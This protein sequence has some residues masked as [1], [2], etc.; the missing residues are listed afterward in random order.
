MFTVGSPSDSFLPADND[1]SCLLF[2]LFYYY[3]F[4]RNVLLYFGYYSPTGDDT[5]VCPEYLSPPLAGKQALS[6]RL[7]HPLPTFWPHWF[8]QF[9]RNTQMLPCSISRSRLLPPPLLFVSEQEKRENIAEHTSGI[10][11]QREVPQERKGAWAEK[12]NIIKNAPVCLPHMC[13]PS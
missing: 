11:S 6:S 12:Q 10:K 7:Q 5:R 8:R 9:F 3:P 4:W 2:H 13:D 1:K